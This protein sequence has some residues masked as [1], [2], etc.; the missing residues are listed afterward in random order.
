MTSLDTHSTV[1]TAFVEAGG[2]RFAYRRLG[3]AD[4]IPVI[5]LQDFRGTMDNWDPA[6]IDGLAA[7]RPVILFDNRGIGRTSGATPDNVADMADDAIAF[8]EA[9]ELTGVDVLGFS[10]GGMIAQQIIF[11]RSGLIRR[12]VLVGTGG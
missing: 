6:V 12:A 1:P 5:M 11:D 9:L 4:A 3:H 10:L 2:V 8:I 7:E